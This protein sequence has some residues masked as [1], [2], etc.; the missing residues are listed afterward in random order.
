MATILRLEGYQ[1]QVAYDGETALGLIR[2]F[3]PEAVLSD[4]GLPGIDGHELARRI[5]QDPGLSAG[6]KLVAALTGYA[7]PEARRR[8]HEAGFDH[9][10]VKPSEP[11]VLEKLLAE[12]AARRER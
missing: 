7:G 1:V 6:V 4:I 10:L 11:A 8:S 3:R 2:R 12:V 9:H 5:R